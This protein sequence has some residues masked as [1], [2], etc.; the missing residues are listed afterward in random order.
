MEALPEFSSAVV[1]LVLG[2]ISLAGATIAL[3]MRSSKHLTSLTELMERLNSNLDESYRQRAELREANEAQAVRIDALEADLRRASGQITALQFDKGALKDSL[4]ALKAEQAA[5]DAQHQEVVAALT[6]QIA[7]FKAELDAERK[8]RQALERALDAERQERE[9][10]VSEM[11]AEIERLTQA[12]AK[13]VKENKALQQQIGDLRARANHADA[14]AEAK[15]TNAP[16]PPAE[17]KE[18]GSGD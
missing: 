15:D 4:D 2:A 18:Q 5:R 7:T 3:L 14:L 8:K 17:A 16:E 12:N 11:K 6:A 13:L 9:R 10:T 1:A